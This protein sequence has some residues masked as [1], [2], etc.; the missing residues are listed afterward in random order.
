M[1]K[2]KKLKILLII[3]ARMGSSRFPG[4]P[5]KKISGIPMIG[6]VYNN[7]C[8][9]KE[10][11]SVVVAT[12]DKEIA[13]YVKSIN[14]NS[15]MTSKKHQRA[16]DRCA[17]AL[18]KLEKLNRI[19][20]DIVIMVQ[21]D[22]PMVNKKMILD[23]LKPFR[24]DHNKI[25]QV[26]N[27]LGQIKSNRELNDKNCIKVVCDK[28]LN[29]MYFSRQS[30]PYSMKSKF[31]CSGKQVCIIPFRRDFLLLYNKLKPTPLEESESIDMLRVL[32]N[33]Y[34]VKMVP[35]S[36]VSFPVDTPNDLKKV[37]L[38]IKRKNI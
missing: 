21:G 38:I 2:R 10:V 7:V 9:I 6:R 24:N 28:Y 33:G 34:D 8:Q 12:C 19:K 26:V 20:Y 31:N 32:E 27:L 18:I 17:E 37:Q 14:G 36:E 5:L 13:R 15:I 3:P 30:I 25:V 11:T 22:E 1:K 35:T 23:S 16:S 4:K 29:A